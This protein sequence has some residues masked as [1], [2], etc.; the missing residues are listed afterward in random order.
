MRRAV[1]A[2]LAGAL[3][4]C[5]VSVP[6]VD[7]SPQDELAKITA[8]VRSL[9]KWLPG[10]RSL[11]EELS[12]AEKAAEKEAEAE[13]VAYFKWTMVSGL[14][15]LALTFIFGYLLEL[16]HITI[17]P[18]AAVHLLSHTHTSR[19]A[20]PS[21]RTPSSPRSCAAT[22]RRAGRRPAC[23]PRLIGGP[24]LGR[25]AS[26]SAPASR[27]SPSTTRIRSWP[28]TRSSTSSSS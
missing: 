27:G 9:A 24:S 16:K 14:V 12:A 19:E 22:S 25:L 23:V 17:L 8:P 15:A 28:S 26:S 1:A 13:D 2:P 18:E 7:S 20:M 6:A 3:L 11:E 10:R 21:L 5:L 4:L